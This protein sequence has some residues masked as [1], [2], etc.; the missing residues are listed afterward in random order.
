MSIWKAWTRERL[1]RQTLHIVADRLHL[2]R[3]KKVAKV[4]EGFDKQCES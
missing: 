2:E 1:F 4:Y 3:V